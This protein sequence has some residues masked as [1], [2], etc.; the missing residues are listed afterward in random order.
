[1]SVFAPNDVCFSFLHGVYE[2]VWWPLRSDF[3]LQDRI[4]DH[5]ISMTR[6]NMSLMMEGAMLEDF[7]MSLQ[8]QEQTDQLAHLDI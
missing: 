3:A 2:I 5:R 1:M 6:T 8:L 7:I 4:T